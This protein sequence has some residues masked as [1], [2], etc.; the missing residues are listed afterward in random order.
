MPADMKTLAEM[1]GVSK[2]TVHRALTNTGRISPRTK[3]KVLAL[4][5]ELNYRPNRLARGLRSRRSASIGVVLTGI[6]SSYSSAL[7]EGIETI[8]FEGGYSILLSC[9]HCY[10]ELETKHLDV[11]REK[12]VDGII[13]V[14]AHPEAN[15]GYYQQMLDDGAP[16][17]FMDRY[18]PEVDAYCV[19]TDN[20]TGGYL[21]AK[22]LTELG[23][24]DL[25]F[26]T[27]PEIERESTSVCERLAGFT[28]GAREAGIESVQVIG[29]GAEECRP[30]EEYA[31]RAI[32]SFFAS[33]TRVTAIMTVNDNLAFGA[34]RGLIE[35]G[36]RVP[37]DVSLVGYDDL[38]INPYIH[39]AMTAVSQ[40]KQA[41]GREAVRILLGLI[42]G[43]ISKAEPKRV[44]LKPELIVRETTSA[45]RASLKEVVKRVS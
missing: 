19:M 24:R 1:L 6:K 38:D 28:E 8:A 37:D 35:E 20:R 4:A 17:V 9:S 5:K 39:P 10:P 18:V 16:V 21:A 32:R 23:H 11:L 12:M 27:T 33:G 31:R 43:R 15:A 45:P 22:H 40:P 3:E 34:L 41:M 44:L 2:T 14:P 26:F 13:L 30:V 29:P 25:A 7:L 36:L 42:E